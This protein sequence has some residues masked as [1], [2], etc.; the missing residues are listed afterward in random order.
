[1]IVLWN[2]ACL[3]RVECADGHDERQGG[4]RRVVMLHRSNYMLLVGDSCNNVFSSRRVVVWDHRLQET[5]MYIDFQQDV[6]NVAFNN[7]VIVTAL[8]K[9]VHVHSFSATPLC[10]G[11]FDCQLSTLKQPLPMALCASGKRNL[12]CCAGPVQGDLLLLN[13]GTDEHDRPVRHV[14]T[15]AHKGFVAAVGLNRDGSIVATA[16]ETGTLIRFFCTVK[17]VML[18][19]VRLGFER[20][21]RVRDIRFNIEG[22]HVLVTA[23]TTVQLVATSSALPCRGDAG[24][25]AQELGEGWDNQ[26]SMLN[27]LGG[28][29][30]SAFGQL[31]IQYCVGKF[32]LERTALAAFLSTSRNMLAAVSLDGTYELLRYVPDGRHCSREQQAVF[33]DLK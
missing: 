2:M 13:C 17:R 16:S 15:S 8:H 21:I 12:L 28:L 19:E 33:L 25:S 1:M 24:S 31:Q 9:S 30:K 32:E 11:R 3:F 5:I 7:D 27:S 6:L 26:V 4:F 10:R 18:H 22:S 14:I 23:G 20:S 29:F